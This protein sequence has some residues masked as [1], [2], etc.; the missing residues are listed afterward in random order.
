MAP[1]PDGP[2]PQERRLHQV[3]EAYLRAVE[4]GRA[5]DRQPLLAQHPDL[6]AELAAFFADHD[7]LKRLAE[8]LRA[9]TGPAP[10]EGGAEGGQTGD[11]SPAGEPTL[12]PG[13]PEGGEGRTGVY[14]P[15]A[16]EPLAPGGAT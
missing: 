12:G 14:S 9:A 1:E 5:P 13:E 10:T 7:Q 2:D 3:L 16:T 11:Y 6:A 4:E 8:P 15:P